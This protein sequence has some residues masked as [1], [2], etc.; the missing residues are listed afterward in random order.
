MKGMLEDIGFAG[1]SLARETEEGLML[2]DGHLRKELALDEEVPVLI[3][4]VTEEEADKLLA[5]FDPIVGLAKADA[6]KLQELLGRVEKEG[7]SKQLLTEVKEKYGVAEYEVVKVKSLSVKPPPS[8]T[9]VLVG[10]STTKFGRISGTVEML[11]DMQGV[12]VETTI[13]SDEKK[14]EKED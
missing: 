7:G 8:L 2:I 13:G 5:F 3:L 9:W 11:A 14:D 6:G 10:I 4:D 12:I 1:A